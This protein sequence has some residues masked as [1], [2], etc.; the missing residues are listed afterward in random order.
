MVVPVSEPVAAAHEGPEIIVYPSQGVPQAVAKVIVIPATQLQVAQR[1][2][3]GNGARPQTTSPLPV[4]VSSTIPIVPLN[5]TVHPSCS[6]VSPTVSLS[7]SLSI[8]DP[9]SNIVTHDVCRPFTPKELSRIAIRINS[10]WTTVAGLTNLF[11]SYDIDNISSNTSFHDPIEKATQ[12]LNSFKSRLGKR[13]DLAKLLRS[14]GK[15]M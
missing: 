3:D 13:E 11:Q 15:L 12:M 6:F 4:R 5:S 1:L 14:R 7:T 9:S 2:P 10:V 8:K